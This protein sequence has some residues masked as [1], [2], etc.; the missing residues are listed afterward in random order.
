MDKTQLMI[1]DLRA[2]LFYIKADNIPVNSINKELVEE[3]E[4]VLLCYMLNLQESRSIEPNNEKFLDK[5]A[6][7]GKKAPY[8]AQNASNSNVITLPAKK[9]LFSQYRAAEPLN[10][11]EWLNAAIEQQKDGLWERNKPEN[12]LYIR[13]LY[14]DGM[15]VTQLFRPLAESG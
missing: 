6:F 9:Y 7:I 4:E 2:P 15:F 8:L 14:E 12:T 1:L 5:P 11:E 10:R 3:N 13:Y